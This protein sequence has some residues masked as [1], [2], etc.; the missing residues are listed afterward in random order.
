MRH[1]IR[2]TYW[3]RR[4]RIQRRRRIMV[5]TVAILIFMLG[6]PV[7]VLGA[8]KYDCYK[9]IRFYQAYQACVAADDCTPTK[10]QEWILKRYGLGIQDCMADRWPCNP[11][12][13]VDND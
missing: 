2:H 13:G 4:Q 6:F 7:L 1:D 5:N 3:A 11:I 8:M 12:T 10:R 9:K